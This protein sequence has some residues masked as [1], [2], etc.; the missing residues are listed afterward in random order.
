MK[1][2][3]LPLGRKGRIC[4]H[5]VACRG[6]LSAHAL[7]VQRHPPCALLQVTIAPVAAH[8]SAQTIV[9]VKRPDRVAH[10]PACLAVIPTRGPDVGVMGVVVEHLAVVMRVAAGC[11]EIPGQAAALRINDKLSPDK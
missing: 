4:F 6:L 3:L 10:T 5:K 7:L 8:L 2:L 11:H 1:Y 9:T